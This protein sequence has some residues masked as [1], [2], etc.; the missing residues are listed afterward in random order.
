MCQLRSSDYLDAD[1]GSQRCDREHVAM[2]AMSK[3]RRPQGGQVGLAAKVRFLSSPAAYLPRP[4]RVEARETHMSWLFLTGRSV[5]KLKKPVRYP[6][7]DF[8]SLASRKWY[9]SAEVRLNRRLAGKVYRGV[10][11]LCRDASGELTIGRP[12]EIVDWLV[13]MEQLPAGDMLDNRIRAGSVA[14]DDIVGL[15]EKLGQFYIAAAPQL[16]D[17]GAYLA[18]L[19]EE[20]AANRRLLL[21]RKCRVPSVDTEAVL[22]RVERLL[23]LRTP[24]I[25]ER[26]ARGRVV[27]GHGD[28]R[29]EH[30]C[31]AHPPVVIDCL[32]FDR[33]MRLLDP[34]DEVNYLGQECEML[35]AGWIGPLLLST[36]EGLLGD[37]PEP[38]LLATYG[39]FRAVLRARICVAHLLD[40]V[41]MQP[42][43]WPGEAKRYLTLAMEQCVKAGG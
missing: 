28:L 13:E 24:A 6:F 42:E 30:V 11:A 5:F 2:V 1:Q 31:V 35:G 15:G 32:E 27:E 19:A 12:G 26:I 10:V 43:R 25:K 16:R 18:H 33:K 34:Y 8:T 21:H 22:D 38:K 39:A 20:S 40:P 14:D 9:C 17:G 7:L 37:P 36:V 23:Q 41:P 3:A 29:P 4:E